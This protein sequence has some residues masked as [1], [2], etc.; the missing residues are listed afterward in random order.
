MAA[1]S[2]GPISIG[3]APIRNPL[4]IESLPTIYEPLQAF[5]LSLIFVAVASLLV[6]LP[7]ASGAERQQ[8]K[9]ITYV[10]AVAA[11][12]SIL[13][14][15]VFEAIDVRWLEIAAYA[16]VLIGIAGVPTAVGIAILRYRLYDIDLIINR[17]LVYGTL[18]ASVVALY[19]LVVGALG[20]LF[21]EG[22]N[23]A[24]S[25]VATG[26]VA[27]LFA[28]LREQL[29]RGVNRL[30]YGERDDP[31]SVLSRLGRRLEATIAPKAAL[32]TIVETIAQA[33]KVP[34]VAIN[35]KLDGDQFETV[36]EHGARKGEPLL[37][38]LIYQREN[39]GQLVVAPRAPGEAFSAADMRLLEDLA[40]QVEVTV[41][42]VRL[43]VDLQRSRERLVTTREEERRRL[44]RDLH[45]GLGPTLGYLT[46]GLDT[47]RRLFTQDP[48]G[49]EALLLELK[50]KTQEAVSEVRRLVYDLRPPALDDLGLVPAI[51]Q[52]AANHGLLAEEIPTGGKESGWANSKNGIVF[53][54][55][56][57]ERLPSLPAAVEVAS[58]RI[59]QEAIVNASRHSGARSCRVSLSLDE[60]ECTLELEVADDGVGIP[61]HRS[62]GVGMSS[63]RERAEELGGALSAEAL[64]QGGTRVLARLPLSQRADEE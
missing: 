50:A 26:V 46:L 11:S 38:P 57:A 4:G 43:S 13:R 27:V 60:A 19:V 8:I 35:L 5:M 55:K 47:A 9:W 23:L 34:Y 58:Y 45:D 31:Y 10:A 12:A 39:V 1:F 2:P 59:A 25:L 49:A 52:Q 42:A 22:S 24:V 44:R 18:T 48:K 29:Q 14:Y 36:A 28:P 15:V 30:T 40:R 6:R 20:M 51:R 64:P 61:E 62:A 32:E 17:T 53:T 41:H 33:L 54:V 37:L 16:L 7:R 56:A 63:M 21:R 3:L